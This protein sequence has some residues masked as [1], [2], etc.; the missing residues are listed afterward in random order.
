M[1]GSGVGIPYENNFNFWDP[2]SLSP[3]TG[4]LSIWL[5]WDTGR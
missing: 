2:L 5:K 3:Q 4:G 1:L